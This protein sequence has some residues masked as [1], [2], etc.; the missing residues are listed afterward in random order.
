M[1]NDLLALSGYVNMARKNVTDDTDE[2]ETE[3]VDNSFEDQTEGADVLEDDDEGVSFDMD[4]TEAGT[5]FPTLPKGRYPVEIDEVDYGRSKAGNHM[6][7][8]RWAVLNGDYKNRKLFSWVVWTQEQL[9][10]AKQFLLDIGRSDLA[11][12]R[13]SL[14]RVQEIAN[15]GELLGAR[16]IADVTIRKYEGE[17]RNNIR[18]IRPYEESD[19]EGEGFGI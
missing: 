5:G 12:G 18:R 15:S 17:H 11:Q 2:T 19:D 14:A 7:T 3:T 6:W 4:A 1:V 13:L 16:G 10:Q 8:V 9:P